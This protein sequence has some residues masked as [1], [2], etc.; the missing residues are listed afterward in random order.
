MRVPAG[1]NIGL[2][3]L[4]L[5]QAV[6]EDGEPRPLVASWEEG[7]GGA[8]RRLCALPLLPR[9]WPAAAEEEEEEARPE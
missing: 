8:Q 2:A 4:R 3:L 7:E 5:E 6:G 1:I 9:W